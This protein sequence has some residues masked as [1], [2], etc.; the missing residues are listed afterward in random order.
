[1]TIELPVVL[2]FTCPNCGSHSLEEIINDATITRQISRIDKSG[3]EYGDQT[4]D[5][6]MVDRYQCKSCGR[7]LDNITNVEELIEFLQI[8]QHTFSA[9]ELLEADIDGKIVLSNA[10]LQEH[11][12]YAA[13][14]SLVINWVDAMKVG[15]RLRLLVED[16]DDVVCVLK[17]WKKALLL[18]SDTR[19]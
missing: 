9:K 4:E 14:E 15:S 3:V 12:A 1:M 10:D 17:A 13:A 11:A 18:K 2:K 7:V 8:N 16:I 6:G 5:F 19:Y